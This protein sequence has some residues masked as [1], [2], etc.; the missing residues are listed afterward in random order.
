MLL[1]SYPE[2]GLTIDWLIEALPTLLVE[3][4][5]LRAGEL[6]ISK[7]KGIG[8]TG[9]R[10]MSRHELLDLHVFLA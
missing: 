2:S 10:P 6:D 9:S 8:C 1:K 3:P 4:R 5:K 7:F